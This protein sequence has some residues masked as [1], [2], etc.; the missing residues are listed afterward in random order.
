MDELTLLRRLDADTPA[1]SEAALTDAFNALTERMDAAEQR[2]RTH[3]PVHR[4]SRKRLLRASVLTAAAAALVVG[5]VL[6]DEIGVAG[7][8]PGDA[9]AAEALGKA[10][11]NT[12]RSADPK[13][14][15]GQYLAVRT[16]ATDLN[17]ST[18][19]SRRPLHWLSRS[20]DTEWIPRDR[21]DVWSLQRSGRRPVEY[22][23]AAAKKVALESY[24]STSQ[25]YDGR[26]ELVRGRNGDFYGTPTDEV[27]YA[28]L[29][30]DPRVLL[31]RIYRTTIGQGQS[32][33]GE[34]LEWIADQLRTGVV[35]ADVR[36]AMYR[37]A[38]LIPGVE[39]VDRRAVL[40]GRRGI[41]IGRVESST[42]ERQEIVVDPATGLLIGER[43]VR[44]RAFEDVPAGS[45]VESTSVTTTV[46]NAAPSGPE[47]RVQ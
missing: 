8:P 46:V 29:P 3:V 9:E 13:V 18:D 6:T 28:D 10:A 24:A 21:R 44:T 5:L 11:V 22:F 19:G 26:D 45:V 16:E 35:P 41:A 23:S 20:I 1:P 15:P 32:P 37:A 42:G 12:I 31:N 33:D 30:R 34:A 2:G 38:A 4:R 25:Q 36:A 47:H 40:D 7:R 27:G 14:K 17:E 43:A 39:V